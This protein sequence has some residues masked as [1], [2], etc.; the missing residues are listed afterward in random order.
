M[1]CMLIYINESKRKVNAC[2]IEDVGLSYAVLEI[3]YTVP[4][5]C[6][7][8][9]FRCRRVSHIFICLSNTRFSAR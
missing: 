2:N 8:C 9:C 7:R 3:R 5:D 1:H 6:G 4:V